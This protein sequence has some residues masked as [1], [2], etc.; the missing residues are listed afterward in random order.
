MTIAFDLK[1]IPNRVTAARLHEDLRARGASHYEIGRF[2][3]AVL[4]KR[5]WPTQTSMSDFFKVSNSHVSR[6]LALA[7]IPSSVV[8]ALGGPERI[9]FRVG[10]LLLGALNEHGEQELTRRALHAG[11]FGC[12]SPEEI[13][14]LVVTNRRPDRGVGKVQIRLSR[15]TRTLRVEIPELERFLPHLAKL[16]K[17]FA[18]ALAMLEATLA[19][20][21]VNA[22]L[23][24]TRLPTRPV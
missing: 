11:A 8:G 6:T 18:A 17:T 12:T 9:T 21:A 3:R 10:D 22:S 19:S 2:Y 4:D 1:R 5:F 23:A 20:E 7:R 16:E 15:D 13:L 14:E 24:T